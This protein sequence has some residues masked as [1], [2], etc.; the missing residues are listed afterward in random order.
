MK[1]PMRHAL[2]WVTA[3]AI[4]LSGPVSVYSDDE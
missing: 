2:K 1:L 4:V 3:G